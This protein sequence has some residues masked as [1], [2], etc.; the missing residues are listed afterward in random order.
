MIVEIP[1]SSSPQ[2]FNIELAG[3]TRRLTFKWNRAS[4]CWVMDVAD[5][6][7]VVLVAGIP[8]VTGADLLAQFGYLNLGGKMAAATDHD[9]AAVPT[10]ENLGETSHLYFQ[11]AAT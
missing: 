11:P 6:N 2:K 4:H 10:F 5:E 9:D 3:T 1:L 7:D 8:L